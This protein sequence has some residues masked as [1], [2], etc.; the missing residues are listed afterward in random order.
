MSEGGSADNSFIFIKREHS[1]VGADVLL[2]GP[3]PGTGALIYVIYFQKK[4][5]K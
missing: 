4:D 5:E 2:C 3:H 1:F